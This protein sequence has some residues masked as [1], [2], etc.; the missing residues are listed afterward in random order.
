MGR[1]QSEF[2]R[3]L[4]E[5]MEVTKQR[6]IDLAEEANLVENTISRWRNADYESGPPSQTRLR[7]LEPALGLPRGVLLG[8]REGFEVALKELKT[9]AT[10]PARGHEGAD[11]VSSVTAGRTRISDP[12]ARPA[13]DIA[14][15]VGDVVAEAVRQVIAS[16]ELNGSRANR[17]DLR[18]VL[19]QFAYGLRELGADVSD[20]WAAIDYLDQHMK[21]E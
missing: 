21:D 7:N 6:G 16:N 20:L 8:G 19:R 11:G 10:V 15:M 3:R 5:A 4:R 13:G 14:S 17:Q 12:S 2:A 9:P 18:D 1:G